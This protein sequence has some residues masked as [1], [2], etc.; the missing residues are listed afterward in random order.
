VL[1]LLDQENKE[2]RAIIFTD[3]K[4]DLKELKSTNFLLNPLGYKPHADDT[5]II[6]GLRNKKLKELEYL[7]TTTRPIF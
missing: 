4:E 1:E 5:I 7:F 6:R 3:N 2:E